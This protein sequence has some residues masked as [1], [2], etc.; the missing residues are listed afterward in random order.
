[1]PGVRCRVS[2]AG[3]QVPG[4]RITTDPPCAHPYASHAISATWHLIPDIRHPTPDT[5]HPTPDTRHPTPH[6]P[7]DTQLPDVMLSQ[8][9]CK[10]PITN[11]PQ[12][13]A[14]LVNREIFES[15]L[16]RES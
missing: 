2:G 11:A 12:P 9:L 5:R 6:L 14:L 7:P 8:G 16:R 1:V 13:S 4:V 10:L 3:C 15:N